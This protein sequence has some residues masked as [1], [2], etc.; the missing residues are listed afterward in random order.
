[1]NEILNFLQSIHPLS[2]PLIDHLSKTLKHKQLLKKDFLLKAGH[3]SRSV[4][5]IQQGLLWAFYMKGD[6]EVTSWFMKEGDISGVS[7][8]SF[9]EQKE[10]YESIQALEDCTLYYIDHQELEYIYRHFPEFNSIGRLLTIK[11]HI[12]WVKQLY[13]IRMQDADQRY[14]W[15]LENDSDLLTRVPAKYIASYL[16]ITPITLSRMKANVA[17]KRK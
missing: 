8:E 5:F 10:S 15:L 11:Y 12:L 9:Y 17:K 13:A 2:P 16:D 7:I 1:M 6:T 14:R 3:I 4:Y